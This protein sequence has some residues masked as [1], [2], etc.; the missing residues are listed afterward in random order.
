MSV[1]MR[2]ENTLIIEPGSDISKIQIINFILLPNSK[3]H[4]E[5]PPLQLHM[6]PSKWSCVSCAYS[7]RRSQNQLEVIFGFTLITTGAPSLFRSECEWH[8]K[9]T[10]YSAH[11]RSSDRQLQPQIQVTQVMAL[12]EAFFGVCFI[13]RSGVKTFIKY[14]IQYTN[15]MTFQIIR[16]LKNVCVFN[17]YHKE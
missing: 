13:L 4:F 3:K 8:Y 14:R 1:L 7:Q 15:N 6:K 11:K 16:V 10:V 17:S 12:N 9:L 2:R 5:G